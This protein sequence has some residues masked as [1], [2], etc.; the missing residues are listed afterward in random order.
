MIVILEGCN[1]T[2]K[3]TFAKYL[4]EHCGFMRFKNKSMYPRMQELGLEEGKVFF[5]GATRQLVD[6]LPTISDGKDVVLDRLHLTEWVYSSCERNYR[7]EWVW[8]VDE[9]LAKMHVKLVLMTDD[10]ELVNERNGRDMSYLMDE[11]WEA[12]NGSLIADRA[13][14]NL[15]EG[16]YEICKGMGLQVWA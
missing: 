8:E 16:L 12:W 4:E 5:E 1:K 3:S 9:I 2:G 6:M 14:R 13:T 11:F 7:P 10:V 15:N